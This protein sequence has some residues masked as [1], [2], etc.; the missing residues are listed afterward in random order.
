MIYQNPPELSQFFRKELE[1]WALKKLKHL[2]MP[3]I[4]KRV[5]AKRKA[6]HIIKA[7]SKMGIPL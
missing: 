2:K 5:L 6:D 1:K 7:H 4:R 3:M